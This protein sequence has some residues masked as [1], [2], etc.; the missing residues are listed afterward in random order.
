M[1]VWLCQLSYPY[2]ER[3]FSHFLTA[4]KWALRIIWAAYHGLLLAII[5][6]TFYDLAGKAE[7]Y[8]RAKAMATFIIGKA[9][10][11]GG[12]YL[13]LSVR[14][15]GDWQM[16]WQEEDLKGKATKVQLR[17]T[18]LKP[19]AY[20]H[21]AKMPSIGKVQKGQETPKMATSATERVDQ[22]KAKEEA[23]SSEITAAAA[24]E[25]EE[26]HPL[27]VGSFCL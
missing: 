17:A 27:V 4:D 3:L 13:M 26:S 19:T 12:A 11:I 15:F 16:G 5:G 22:V 14:D 6:C 21:S 7:A 18:S 25:G 24:E 20:P 1:I 9:L 2:L 8:S 23:D 10:Y